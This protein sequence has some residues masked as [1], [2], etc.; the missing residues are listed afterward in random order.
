MSE[1]RSVRNAAPESHPHLFRGAAIVAGDGF[2]MSGAVRRYGSARPG[3]SPPTA[4]PDMCARTAE[5]R[6][7]TINRLAR[8]AGHFARR[9]P[10]RLPSTEAR[11]RAAAALS[12]A[13]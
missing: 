13:P 6:T 3:L 1:T 8:Q 4:A 5:A 11:L 10:K 2:W 7:T 9:S 12:L